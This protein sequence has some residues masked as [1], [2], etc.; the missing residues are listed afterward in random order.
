MAQMVFEMSVLRLVDVRPFQK[1]DEMIQKVNA[2]ERDNNLP[3]GPTAGSL[4]SVPEAPSALPTGSSSPG[5]PADLSSD[6]DRICQEICGR[7]PMFDH[8]LSQCKVLSFNE[9]GL[10]LG[11]ADPVTL[12]RIQDPENLQVVI[13]AVKTVCGRETRVEL[14]L[15]ENKN[16]QEGGADTNSD[17]KKV[18]MHQNE[19]RQ[20]TEAEII[21]DAL[22]VFG[23]VVIR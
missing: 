17:K 1:I 20:K 16:S 23:G 8:Y 22:D 14:S 18:I 5:N 21:Q 9:S 7:K 19:S 11:F 12:E 4:K 2:M 10:S 3:A 6:W 15:N 13:D